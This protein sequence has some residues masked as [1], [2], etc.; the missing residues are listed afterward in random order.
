MVGLPISATTV[1]RA[2]TSPF[3]IHDVELS[4]DAARLAFSVGDRWNGY[5]RHRV[6]ACDM[7]NCSGLNTAFE[8]NN[9]DPRPIGGTFELGLGQSKS[10]GSERI[11]FLYRRDSSWSAGDLVMIE[12][13]NLGTWS[14]PTVL[15]SND[16]DNYSGDVNPT[17][18]REPSVLTEAGVDDRIALTSQDGNLAYPVRVDVYDVGSGLTP[19]IGIGFRPSWTSNPSIDATGPN[20][21]VN[22]GYRVVQDT[23]ILEIDPEGTPETPTANANVSGFGVDSA[24]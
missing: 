24:D 12:K 13:D 8:A 3:D 14:P 7:P 20:I 1:F 17:A 18:L 21:L 11:Y 22:V 19:N 10:D 2:S 9:S 5:S 15:L 23:Q 4:R 16:D 6:F